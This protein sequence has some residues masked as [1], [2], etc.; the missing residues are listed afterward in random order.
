MKFNLNQI[1]ILKQIKFKSVLKMIEKYIYTYIHLM[2]KCRLKSNKLHF[3]KG[4]TYT[5]L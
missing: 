1:L 4:V 3:V 2:T 5:V